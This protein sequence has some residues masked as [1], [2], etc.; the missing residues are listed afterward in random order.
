MRMSAV[1]TVSKR[2]ADKLGEAQSAL[3]SGLPILDE[4]TVLSTFLDRWLEDVIR[5]NRSHGHWRNCEGAVRLHLKPALGSVRLVR[6]GPADVQHLLKTYGH[7]GWPT[8]APDLLGS[9]GL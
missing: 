2:G 9:H 4:R 3:A 6:L 1:P 8:T 7:A 5:P